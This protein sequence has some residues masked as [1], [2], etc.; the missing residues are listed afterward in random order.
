ILGGFHEDSPAGPADAPTPTADAAGRAADPVLLTSLSAKIDRCMGRID[1]LETEL[2]TSKKI[3]GG[4]ILTLVSRVKKLERT[5][6]QLRTARRLEKD[7]LLNAQYN[8]FRPKPVI[9]KPPS[10]RQRVDRE[11]SQPSDVPVAST[12]H[13]DHP[14]SAGGGNPADSFQPADSFEPADESNP[15][16]SS[17]VS[18]DFNPV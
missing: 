1:S 6:K 12:H 11:T 9:S 3:L 17:S 10:K 4:A 13:A 15:A 16:V 18:A 7:R 2:G 14:D 8:L 5:V